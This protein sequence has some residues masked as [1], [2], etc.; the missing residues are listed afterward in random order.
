M[1]AHS[2]S[3]RNAPR[4]PAAKRRGGGRGDKDGDLMMDVA[5]KGRGRIGK[6]AA[7][8]SSGRD[9]TSRVSR[10]DAKGGILSGTARSAILRQAASG[11]VS[12]RES[13]SA[14]R[15]GLVELQITGWKES[16]ASSDKDGGVSSLIR[17]MEKKSSHRLGS[18][19][20]DVRIKKSRRDGNTV[21][22]KVAPED[23]GAL[24]RMNGYG[25][26]GTTVSIERVGESSQKA[27]SSGAEDT[28]AM[29]RG[30]LERRYNFE[31]KVLDLSG[32]GG[33][34]ELNKKNVFDQKSTTKKIFPALMRVLD[35]S[36]DSDVEK[37]EAITGVT[38]AN[39]GLSELTDVTSLSLTLPKLQNLDLSNNNFE[40]LSALDIWRRRFY[41]LQHLV[42]SGNPIEQNEPEYPAEI[43][44]WYPNLRM[45][46]DVQVRTEEEVASKAKIELPFPIRSALFQDE[47]GIA[48][49]F[50][51]TFF[52]GFDTDRA[53][54]AAH[55]YDEQSDF[56]FAINTQAPRDPAGSEQT[57][58]QEWD[59]YIR[60]S[61]NLKKISQL[62]ARQNRHFRGAKAVA[63][64]FNTLPKT[65]H[66]DLASEA[67]KWMIEAH[68]QPAVPDPSGQSP[69]GVDGFMIT[70]HG[71]FEELDVAT[72]Q[73]K[74]KRSF[75]RTFI[76]GPGGPTGVRVVN[77]M[78]TVR[79]YGGAQAFEPD[80]LEGWATDAQPS[81]NPVEAVAQLPAGLTLEMAE[82]MVVELQ[83]QTGM[84]VQYS[85]DCLEQ[86]RWDFQ[87]GVEAFAS[88]KANLPADAFVQQA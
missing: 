42:L 75:D 21:F 47:G 72:G 32:L 24:V 87:K 5:V 64:A 2:Q 65:K 76:V 48:E 3:P 45:F 53:A 50:V 36:F 7:S 34:E 11:D 33:D 62:P 78:L 86:V 79:A 66:P 29:L 73:G 54:L 61:R 10:G 27:I 37:N 17:W 40:K 74:K 18:R 20:R 83:K 41:N 19:T 55:Y 69:G 57:E 28:K 70:V 44:K 38:L 25:W 82:Q 14:P 88:V 80:Q 35:L 81:T 56:S 8:A 9:L 22:I 58:K 31:T 16:K 60:N 59:H 4:G 85:K 63:D 49:N 15:G 67:R 51:R 30:V 77:D 6:S 12:M 23:V 39:N 52:I 43:V 71:E 26:A 46:N 13:R 1:A 84:T 68:I